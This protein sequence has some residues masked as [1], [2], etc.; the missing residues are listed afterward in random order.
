[1][2]TNAWLAV[3][4]VAT[5]LQLGCTLAVLIGAWRFYDRADRALEELQAN[6]RDVVHRVRTADDAVRN[7]VRKTSQAAALLATVTRR[8]AWPVIGLARAVGI[9]ASTLFRSRKPSPPA[10][11]PLAVHPTDGVA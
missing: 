4:A 9:A 8:R 11:R 5:L 3:I 6:V 1:V 2:T 7:A 10:S